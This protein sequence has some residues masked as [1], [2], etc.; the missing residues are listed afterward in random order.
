VESHLPARTRRPRRALSLARLA[1]PAGLAAGALLLV[2]GEPAPDVVAGTPSSAAE[3]RGPSLAPAHLTATPGPEPGGAGL[4]IVRIEQRLGADLAQEFVI[5]FDGPVPDDRIS[6]VEDIRHV[7][8]PAI[9]YTTQEWRPERP[10]SLLTCGAAHFGFSPPVPV[11]GQ[12]DVLMPARWFDVP[13]DPDE[14]VWE[15]AVA[16]TPLC[17]P[18]DGF[19]QFAIWV[20]TSHD[21]DDIR[22]YIDGGT[23]LVVEI[24]PGSG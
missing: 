14:I 17:A 19:V 13:P 21:P 16:K 6:F 20:P 7:D 5:V 12:A 22:V 15:G 24:R 11:V 4:S 10:T 23:R 9:A 8:A 18:R 1:A 2:G 3:G